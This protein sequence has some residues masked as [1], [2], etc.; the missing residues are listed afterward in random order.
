VLGLARWCM[1]HRRR[2]VVAWV[3][4]AVAATVAAHAVGPN[5]VTVY[6]LP[7]TDSQRAHDLLTKEFSTQ[8]G[9]VDSI[10]FRASHGTIDSPAV[11]AAITPLL[12]RGSALPHVTGVVSPYS[13]RGAVQVSR[14]RSTAF[15]TVNYD[16][17]ANELATDA[18]RPLLAAVDAVHV[19]G[20]QVDAGGQVVEAAEGFNIGPATE[21]GVVAALFI[22][23]ITFGSLLAAGMPLITAG[24]GLITGV[25]LIG[26]ATRVTNLS[27]VS[28]DLALMI[29][30]GVGIDY[31]LFIVTRFR[32][33]YLACGDLDNALVEAMDTSGRAIL[34]AG[35]CDGCD[36]AA[37]HVRHWCRV[38]VWPRDRRCDRRAAHARRVAHAASR[39]SVALRAAGRAPSQESQP[40][41]RPTQR[42][43]SG[44]W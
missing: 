32:E 12:A 23:L 6:S 26:L 36:R 3:L 44:R 16:K 21:V 10:V 2:V 37:W 31:S 18:G 30:L 41:T 35:R 14:D 19:P 8:S 20:L 40:A 39:A 29:G 5:Y 34:L 33:N 15:A 7:G 4:L 11:R 42:H 43:T 1:A 24:L 28:P 22:L 38:H 27:N 17:P 9:D 25:A 13:A